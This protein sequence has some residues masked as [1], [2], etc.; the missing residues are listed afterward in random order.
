MMYGFVVVAWLIFGN[1][2][3][4]PFATMDACMEAEKVAEMDI[5]YSNDY[6]MCVPTGAKETR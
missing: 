1:D 2:H 5:K 4:V 6:I 3:A